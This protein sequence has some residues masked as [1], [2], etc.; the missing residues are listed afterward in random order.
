MKSINFEESNVKFA[1]N[2]PE[3]I[4]L[5]AFYDKENGIVVTCYKMS[6]RERITLL[7]TNRIWLSIMTFGQALQPQKM[8]V[9]KSEVFINIVDN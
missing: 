8:N 4:T 1:E 2:Q 6:F 5:P 9:L 7:F 3:Y